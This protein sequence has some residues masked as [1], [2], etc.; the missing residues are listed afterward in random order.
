[1]GELNANYALGVYAFSLGCVSFT[2]DAIR[3]RPLRG[4]YLT[5]CLLFDIGCGFFLAD[6]HGANWST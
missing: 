1:M 4:A 6:A 5:G 2:I 3:S